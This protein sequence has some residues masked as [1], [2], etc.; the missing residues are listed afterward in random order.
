MNESVAQCLTHLYTLFPR[1]VVR[2][3]FLGCSILY[4]RFFFSVNTRRF[5]ET[6]IYAYLLV[7]VYPI[8]YKHLASRILIDDQ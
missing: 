3:Y 8:F 7:L 1:A 5:R 6:A 4:M 2:Q